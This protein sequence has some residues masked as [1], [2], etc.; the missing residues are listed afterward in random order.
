MRKFI[1]RKT[2][3]NDADPLS[4][5]QRSIVF[6]KNPGEEGDSIDDIQKNDKILQKTSSSSS[7]SG[8]STAQK[9]ETSS[10]TDS[11]VSHSDTMQKLKK[12]IELAKSARKGMMHRVTEKSKR[13]EDAKRELSEKQKAIQDLLSK[14]HIPG[15]V[16]ETSI[17]LDVIKEQVGLMNLNHTNTEDRITFD[18]LDS[19][20][21]AI[22][23]ITTQ[24]DN[25]L[26]LVSNTQYEYAEYDVLDLLKSAAIQIDIPYGVSLK[27]PQNSY[28][29]SCDQNKMKSVFQNLLI[30][31]I[32]AVGYSGY[33]HVRLLEDAEN[34]LIHIEDS[35][36]GI[37]QEHMNKI[38]EPMFTTK[39]DGNGLG[40]ARCK[41]II[42]NHKGT[43]SFENNPTTFTITLPKSR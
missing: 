11:P 8:K 32:Q 4:S 25:V 42:T 43:I 35:G 17:P 28:T 34:Y 10:K 12:S 2:D 18:S 5:N 33:I 38:F 37:S 15:T 22:R 41:E 6:K 20:E 14:S 30:N 27:L 24:F 29:I 3:D 16:R 21:K 1:H 7:S 39:V 31:A 9:S 40:L 36:A 19:S 26:G 13:V 23:K